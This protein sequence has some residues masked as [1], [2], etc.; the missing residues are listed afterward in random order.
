MEAYILKKNMTDIIGYLQNPFFKNSIF[1]ILT[2]LSSAGFGFIFWMLAAKMYSAEDVG[3]ATALISSIGL[4]I[5]FS[6]FGLDF[7]IIRFFPGNDRNKIFSTSVIIT[8]ISVIVLGIT[9]IIGVDLF[10]PELYILKSTHNAEIFLISL[11]ISSVTALTAISFVAIRKAAYQLVQ[12]TIMGLR[13]L[14]LIPLIT[15]GAMGVFGAVSISTLIAMIVAMLLLSRSDIKLKFVIDREFLNKSFNFSVSNYLA[16]MFTTGPSLILPI[17][18]LNMLGAEQAAFYYISYTIVSLLFTISNAISTSLFVEG[19]H[20]EALKSTVMK[21]IPSIFI[22]SVPLAAI[23]FIWGGWILERIGE[24]YAGGGFEVLRV[25]V[26]ASFFVGI[27]QLCFAIQ[28][29]QKQTRGLLILSGVIFGLI[30]GLGYIFLDMFGVVGIGY[31]WLVGNALGSV[32]AGVM[33]NKIV[34]TY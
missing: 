17:M 26:I 2:S 23:L 30:V 24:G 33:V 5:M 9:F 15:F 21:S 20:G 4:L 29:V 34:V 1:I 7:S 13:I 32:I 27:N 3:I 16:G 10:S 6:R 28:R 31:A 11:I 12:S 22:L 8:T 14:L 19:S 18:A 25:M